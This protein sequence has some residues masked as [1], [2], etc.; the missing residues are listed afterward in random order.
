MTVL[1]LDVSKLVSKGI[2]DFKPLSPIFN[3]TDCYIFEHV[4][5]TIHA[6][7]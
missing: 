2:F 7:A 5:N 3:G 4:R 1:K 6:S